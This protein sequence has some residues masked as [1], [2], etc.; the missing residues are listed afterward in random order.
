[1]S[2]SLQDLLTDSPCHLSS[3]YDTAHSYCKL[4]G[5]SPMKLCCITWIIVL[6][7]YVVLEY[8]ADE[9]VTR[10]FFLC[11]C[12]F[13]CFTLE[14]VA[15]RCIMLCTC[16]VSIHVILSLWI[17]QHDTGYP[18]VVGLLTMLVKR[19]KIKIMILPIW[20]RTRQNGFL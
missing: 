8:I 17:N 9:D 7:K 2:Y 11:H 10:Q 19:L 15:C 4:N 14:F 5:K 20:V 1:M 13:V 12:W 16:F 6:W 18:R 3:T